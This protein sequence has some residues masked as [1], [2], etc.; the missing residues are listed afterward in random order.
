MS[1]TENWYRQGNGVNGSYAPAAD[2]QY[3][4][5]VSQIS[6]QDQNIG[7][8]LFSWLGNTGGSRYVT[9]KTN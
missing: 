8:S 5:E 1:E 2:I 3:R 6:V 4:P 7:G 9:P